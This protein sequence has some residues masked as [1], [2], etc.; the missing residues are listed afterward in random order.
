MAWV[1]LLGL[2]ATPH[3]DH[4]RI[5]RPQ[6]AEGRHVGHVPGPGRHLGDLL[7]DPGLWG[8]VQTVS[9]MFPIYWVGLGMRSAFLPDA[10]ALEIEA[11][12]ERSRPCWC[13]PPGPWPAVSSPRWWCAEWRAASRAPGRGSQ[14]AGRA[15]GQMT[16]TVYNRIAMLRAERGSPPPAQRG[17]QGPLSDDWL[18][19]T[20]R[21]QPEPLPGAEDRRVFRG[22]D[23]SGLLH[24]AVRQDRQQPPPA[25]LTASPAG[26]DGGCHRTRATDTLGRG[27]CDS[28]RPGDVARQ[29]PP[30]GRGWVDSGA[31]AIR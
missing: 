15:V 22:A 25:R 27:H 4:H 31:R 23:R 13:C 28:S 16:D 3:R 6:R 20:G 2:W 17:A 10:A 26:Q 18:P 29:P 5:P 7:P 1:T 12:G 21:I 30:A 8:W 24:R 14:G 11:P 9:Q 19:G